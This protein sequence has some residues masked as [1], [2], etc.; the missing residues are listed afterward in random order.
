MA[1][2]SLRLSRRNLEA[3]LTSLLLPILLMLLFVYL[4]GGAI[5]TG[6][7]YVTYVVPGVLL[8]SAGFGASMT[9]VTVS[10]DMTGGII[11]RFR[12]M[13]VAGASVLAGHV[14]ASMVRNAVSTLL[15]VGGLRPVHKVARGGRRL[16]LPGELPALSEQ[17]LRAGRHHADLDPRRRREPAR[18]P[19]HRDPAR[20]AAGHPRRLQP[21]EGGGLV[22]G[23]PGR[24]GG[25]LRRAAP[26]ARGMSELSAAGLAGLAGTTVAEVRRL[27]DLAPASDLCRRSPAGLPLLAGQAVEA[28]TA[29]HGARPLALDHARS[30]SSVAWL[31]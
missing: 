6:T 21:L 30:A 17:R 24:L 20:P 23:D 14:V 15:A 31:V 27:V 18:H 25:D 12:S 13:D 7:C 4:F 9:A 16:H 5:Q 1:E 22:P 10:N 26:A 28:D 2:R 11:D 8:L 29:P 3:I 19:R